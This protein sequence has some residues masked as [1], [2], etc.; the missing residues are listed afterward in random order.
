MNKKVLGLGLAAVAVLTLAACGSRD[1]SASNSNAK[2]DLKVAIV[3]DTGGVDDKSFNQSAWEG[4]QAFGE[5][6]GLSKGNG[7]DYLQSQSDSDYAT[8][9]NSLIR[10]GND[11]VFGIG[12]MMEGAISEIAQQQK[13]AHL[14]SLTL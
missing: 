9:L 10:Q 8:N 1:K 12:F 2:T 11:L 13:D 6:N 7:I 3:T 14:V 5:D 4:L